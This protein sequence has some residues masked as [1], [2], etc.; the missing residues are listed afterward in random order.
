MPLF[1]INQGKAKELEEKPFKLEKDI[2]KVFENNLG[3]FM[4]LRLVKSEFSVKSRRIDTLAFDP[5][6]CAFIIIEYKRDKS[7]SV[8]D[9]GIAYLNLM[10]ENKAEFIVEYNE[11]LKANLTRSEV[12]W[13]Q[14]RVAFVASSFTENQKQ[15]TNF[16]DLAIELWEVKRFENSTLLV[17]VIRKSASAPSIKQLAPQSESLAQVSKEIKEYTEKDHY[18]HGS[19]EMVELYERFKEAVLNLSD[20]IDIKP[21]KKEIGFTHN[22]KIFTD[23]CILKNSLKIWINLKRGHLDDPKKIA[24]DVSSTGHWGNGDYQLQVS[25]DKHLEYIMSLVKQGLIY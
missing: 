19:E 2:Q 3:T 18:E 12:D 16:K 22:G 14:T 24:K 8:V 9:Q 25:D 15:A 10:L 6:A 23:I 21:K 20:N 13:S 17:N 4:G 1:T 5:D 11:S 7:N